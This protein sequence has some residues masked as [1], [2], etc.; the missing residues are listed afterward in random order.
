[1]NGSSEHIL[2]CTECNQRLKMGPWELMCPG[3]KGASLCGGVSESPPTLYRAK[4]F[5]GQRS[6]I[7]SWSHIKGF[8]LGTV[9]AAQ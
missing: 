7:S 8:V 3:T 1:M 6:L 2:G 4:E 5:R 9:S